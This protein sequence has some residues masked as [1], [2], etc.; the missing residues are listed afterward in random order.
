MGGGGGGKTHNPPCQLP[1]PRMHSA[2]TLVIRRRFSVSARLADSCASW[3]WRCVYDRE[4]RGY[5]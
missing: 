2:C 1:K 4:R 5:G 3:E